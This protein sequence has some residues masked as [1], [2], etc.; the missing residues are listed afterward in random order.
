MCEEWLRFVGFLDMETLQIWASDLEPL[1][2]VLLLGR[3]GDWM[4][5]GMGCGPSLKP[6][7]LDPVHL[8]Q[9]TATLGKRHSSIFPELFLELKRKCFKRGG[10]KVNAQLELSP[11][12]VRSYLMQSLQPLASHPWTLACPWSVRTRPISKTNKNTG[13]AKRC[14]NCDRYSV[15]ITCPITNRVR[16]RAGHCWMSSDPPRIPPP[17]WTIYLKFMLSYS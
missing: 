2:Q 7:H 11:I 1:T 5:S 9:H 16:G 14:A 12:F 15:I 4:L 13:K 8:Q 10:K 3:N 17:F 6:S